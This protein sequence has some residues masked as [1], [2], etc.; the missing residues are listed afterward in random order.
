MKKITI[1]RSIAVIAVF[2]V[3]AFS[4]FKSSDKQ[5]ATEFSTPTPTSSTDDVVPVIVTTSSADKESVA[6]NTNTDIKVSK[7]AP[8]PIVS[9]PT[10]PSTVYTNGQYQTIATYRSPGGTDKLGVS[11]TITNDVVSDANVTNM[12]SNET[13]ERYEDSFI[14]SYRS[15]VVGK[16]LS[17]LKLD[18]V[19]GASLTTEAFNDAVAQIKVQA[20]S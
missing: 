9:T 8:I 1:I 12:A 19:S 6:I 7:P 11:L 15:Y 14:N 16:K 20:K 5:P 13:S 4:I 18:R 3:A 17:E 2:C 10:L